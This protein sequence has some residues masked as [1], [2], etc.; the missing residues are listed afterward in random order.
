[1]VFKPHHSFPF[2]SPKTLFSLLFPNLVLLVS[3]SLCYCPQRRPN[4]FFQLDPASYQLLCVF[5]GTKRMLKNSQL[6]GHL[7][8]KERSTNSWTGP[9]A[10]TLSF[11]TEFWQNCLIGTSRGLDL[12]VGK[13]S[14][15]SKSL[16]T[17]I[18]TDMYFHK[19]Y[20][21]VSRSEIDGM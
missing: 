2:S 13:G 11:S 5:Y 18:G 6:D 9:H 10:P 8:N 15:K 17:R 12:A 21:D 19:I 1:M 7:A 14:Q 16:F 4:F 20:G 3:L